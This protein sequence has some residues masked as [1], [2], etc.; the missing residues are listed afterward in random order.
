[1]M[2][3]HRCLSP[4]LPRLSRPP[5]RL[6]SDDSA[7]CTRG[8][9]PLSA[10]AHSARLSAV[11]AAPCQSPS[12]LS[13]RRP[14]LPWHHIHEPERSADVS[15]GRPTPTRLLRV[16]VRSSAFRLPSP[17]CQ[18][19]PRR[20]HHP[21]GRPARLAQVLSAW[22]PLRRPSGGSCLA[23]S[24]EARSARV[25]LRRAGDPLD[26]LAH[27]T[28]PRRRHRQVFVVH[29]HLPLLASRSRRAGDRGQ[30]HTPA[31]NSSRLPLARLGSPLSPAPSAAVEAAASVA[32]R[33]SRRD[34]V[35]SAACPRPAPPARQLH[36][37]P[38]GRSARAPSPAPHRT[39]PAS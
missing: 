10:A 21:L 28:P 6:P 26:L 19:S 12:H 3:H 17:L 36:L 20:A 39:V 13:F 1:M 35:R 32:A 38:A 31:E 34:A 33:R 15:A 11:G 4:N 7:S 5:P 30:L 14:R 22:Q 27:P 25:S 24:Q 18:P 8:R 2:L 23:C 29:A 37:A 16:P 9:L